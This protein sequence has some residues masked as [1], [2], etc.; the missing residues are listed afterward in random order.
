MVWEMN[1]RATPLLVT[2]SL[3]LN[4]ALLLR[5]QIV[6]PLSSASAEPAAQ[7]PADPVLTCSG[8]SSTR[9]ELRGL[10]RGGGCGCNGKGMGLSA[11][12]PSGPAI[13]MPKGRVGRK[14]DDFSYFMRGEPTS[15][16]SVRGTLATLVVLV[17]SH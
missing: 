1:A 6:P 13:F 16:G 17:A 8:D 12:K 14:L 15:L 5:P 9:P 3:L 2:A 4:V 10:E 7:V 11:R